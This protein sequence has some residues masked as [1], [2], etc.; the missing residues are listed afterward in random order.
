M[1]ANIPYSSSIDEAWEVIFFMVPEP[2][3]DSIQSL[4]QVSEVHNPHMLSDPVL[5]FLSLTASGKASAPQKSALKWF[6]ESLLAFQL[7]LV[8]FSGKELD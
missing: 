4:A 5:L 1:K 3:S 8:W 6:H 2:V 7:Y